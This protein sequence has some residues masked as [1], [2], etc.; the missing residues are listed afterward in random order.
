MLFDWVY[1]HRLF[2][3]SLDS[4]WSLLL[5]FVSLE[6][7]YYW[8]HRAQHRFPF[9]WA[10][11]R[12]HHSDLSLNVTTGNRHHWLEEPMRVFVVLLPIGLLFDQLNDPAFHYRHRWQP[13]DVVMWDEHATLHLGPNDFF[14]QHRR[15]TRVTAGARSP[16]AKF[17]GHNQKA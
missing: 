5:L 9:L 12:I 13:G 8:F 14:P 6:F 17:D 1:G 4:I 15:L 3:Q 7:F 16:V 10:Q 2:S 11:H